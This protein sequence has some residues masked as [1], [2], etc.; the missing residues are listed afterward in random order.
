MAGRMGKLHKEAQRDNEQEDDDNK[1]SGR[2]RG[3]A[4]PVETWCLWFIVNRLDL[5]QVAQIMQEI[6]HRPVTLLLVTT[7]GP[8][9]Y[10]SQRWRDLR[11][12]EED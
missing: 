8:H 9:H 6:T 4:S 7:N 3:S 12:P 5:F 1:E 10:G 2:D 11:I